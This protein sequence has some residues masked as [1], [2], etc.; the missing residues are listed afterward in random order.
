[1]A[2]TSKNKTYIEAVGRRKTA[3]ARVRL[4]PAKKSAYVFNGRDI[5]SYFPTEN[6][7]S[8]ATEAIAKIKEAG[9]YEVSVLAKGGG[10]RSQAEAAR[11]GI[12]RALVKANEELRKDLKKAGFL[13]RDPRSKERKKFGLKKA[14][15]APQWSKR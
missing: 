8:I 3:V 6:L 12:A 14:R 13:K 15:R 9:H 11:H 5:A 1:M 7:R 2:T 4:F 10:L